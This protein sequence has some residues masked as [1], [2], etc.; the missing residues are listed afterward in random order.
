MLTHTCHTFYQ[1]PKHSSHLIFQIEEGYIKKSLFYEWNGICCG[2]FEGFVDDLS[3]MK[4]GSFFLNGF[5]LVLNGFK[6]EFLVQNSSQFWSQNQEK[7]DKMFHKESRIKNYS[8]VNH[9]YKYGF[10]I[11]YL[12]MSLFKANKKLLIGKPNKVRRNHETCWVLFPNKAYILY[13][14]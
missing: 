1:L 6:L 2:Y 8:R 11:R 13:L 12:N 7:S 3:F 5:K 9:L 14:L 10:I 4:F